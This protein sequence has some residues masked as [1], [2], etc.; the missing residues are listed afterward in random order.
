[1]LPMMADFVRDHVS[2]RKIAGRAQ[3][4]LQVR[5]ELQIDVEMPVGRTVKRTDGRL[6]EPASRTDRAAEED[7]CGLLIAQAALLEDRRP[8]V[9]G[10]AE[11]GCDEIA[12]RFPF[13]G[14]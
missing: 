12:L 5:E 3:P 4:L 11:H 13:A 7:E 9:F 2:L 8:G 1:V 14:R 10:A 6:R